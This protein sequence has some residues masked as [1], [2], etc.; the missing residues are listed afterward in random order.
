MTSILF[1]VFFL[2][3]PTGTELPAKLSAPAE[4]KVLTTTCTNDGTCTTIIDGSNCSMTEDADGNWKD[5]GD[6]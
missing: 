3:A 5:V 6:C 4:D 2:W 1:L